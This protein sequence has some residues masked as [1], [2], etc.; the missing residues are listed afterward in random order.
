MKKAYYLLLLLV[1]ALC[2]CGPKLLFVT[3]YI[4]KDYGYSVKR[5]TYADSH[6]RFELLVDGEVIQT[7]E[8]QKQFNKNPI[9]LPVTEFQSVF[10]LIQMWCHYDMKAFFTK[11][12]VFLRDT[13]HVKLGKQR[14]DVCFYI[15][16]F[17]VLQ[18]SIKYE[19]FKDSPVSCKE[20]EYKKLDEGYEIVFSPFGNLKMEQ[21]YN[22]G[23]IGKTNRDEIQNQMRLKFARKLQKR[24]V[25]EKSHTS[26]SLKWLSNVN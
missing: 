26:Y 11:D 5:Y 14:G 2:G 20:Q 10:Y 3:E 13:E 22:E 18:D 9:Y 6:S 19:V 24:N 1:L 23:I 7:M 12:M 16:D 25:T 21:E 4:P 17:R 8:C 15:D